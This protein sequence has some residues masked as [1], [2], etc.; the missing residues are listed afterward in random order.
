MCRA[1]VPICLHVSS[2]RNDPIMPSFLILHQLG[3]HL[4]SV[5]DLRAAM[6]AALFVNDTCD[7]GQSRAMIVLAVRLNKDSFS[8][9]VLVRWAP[10]DAPEIYIIPP[11]A[12]GRKSGQEC[13]HKTC[14]PYKKNLLRHLGP[15]PRR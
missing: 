10:L 11:L 1:I 9:D 5:R 7:K 2:K 4:P 12:D 6:H 13:I 8:Y 14:T 15:A 3:Q